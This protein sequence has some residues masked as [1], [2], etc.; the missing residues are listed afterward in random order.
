MYVIIIISP[1]SHTWGGGQVSETKSFHNLSCWIVLMAW[2]MHRQMLGRNGWVDDQL[3]LPHF[4]SFQLD[5]M[6]NIVLSCSHVTIRFDFFLLL[7]FHYLVR[8]RWSVHFILRV[9]WLVLLKRQMSRIWK[10][11]SQDIV[12]IP[13]CQYCCCSSTSLK[14]LQKQKT[15]CIAANFW[16]FSLYYASYFIK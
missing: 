10:R 13:Y 16:A 15:N 9:V 7:L 12:K 4:Y 3:Y 8:C 11:I 5:K 1:K 6:V 14:W 2:W